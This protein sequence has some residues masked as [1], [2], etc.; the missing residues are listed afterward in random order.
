MQR[1]VVKVGSQMVCAG[2]PLLMRT[3]MQQISTLRSKY[4]IEV[5]WVTSG[6]IA[7][8]S[9]RTNFANR[10]RTLP[11]KQAL[12]AV[13][14][15]LIMDQYNLALA[16]T[17]L[18][19]AQ[20]LLTIGD[21]RDK[22]RRQNLQNTLKELLRWGVI[23]ILNENDAVATEEIR[24]GDNDALASHVA[25]MMK[26]KRLVLMTDVDGLYDTDPKRNPKAQLIAYRAKIGS[27]ERRMA[28]RKSV[29]SVGTGG[30]ASKWGAA[31]RAQVQH[32]PTHLVRGDLPNNLLDIASG[33]SIGTQI[34]GRYV[35]T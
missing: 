17:G 10:R 7:W 21:I 26:A 35:H 20:V 33:K 32:I 12:S 16:A 5:I 25:V 2:G 31:H 18:L 1:W 30:M 4:Q 9:A 24:F 13:G 34:G 23:P 29:S 15:P 3:W 6:A 14:Q 19:G 11:Q 22:T 28:S 27:A 8:A